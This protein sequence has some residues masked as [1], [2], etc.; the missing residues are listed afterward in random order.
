MWEFLRIEIRR[1]DE[2]RG[3][4]GR[5]EEGM[6]RGH[7]GRREGGDDWEGAGVSEERGWR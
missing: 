7:G 4:R 3:E 6:K 1:Q 2:G 5:R